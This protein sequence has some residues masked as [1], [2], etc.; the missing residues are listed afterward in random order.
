MN[1][2]D[3]ADRQIEPDSLVELETVTDGGD[4]RR[5]ANGFKGVAL[6]YPA[7]GSIAANYPEANNLLPP[8]Y[9]D[10]K[11]KTPS[12]KSLPV[13]VRPMAN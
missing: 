12:G 6:E 10:K 9:H 8:S 2:D 4:V 13:L 5:T 1:E 3:M 11:S 7:R